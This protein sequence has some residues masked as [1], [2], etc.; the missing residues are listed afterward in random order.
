VWLPKLGPWSGENE[1]HSAV[2]QGTELRTYRLILPRVFHS[3]AYEAGG[4]RQRLEYARIAP[5]GRHVAVFVGDS[6]VL[7]NLGDSAAR[8][9]SFLAAD[10]V[11]LRFGPSG[12]L[13]TGSRTELTRYAF[14]PSP[15]GDGRVGP[16][17]QRF[18]V[19][20]G[21]GW[22][23]TADGRLAAVGCFDAGALLFRDQTATPLRLGPQGDVRMTALSPDGRWVVTASHWR[24]AT[25]GVKVWDTRS[26]QL[27]KALSSESGLPQFSPDGAYLGLAGPSIRLW[28]TDSWEEIPAVSGRRFAFSPDGL[29]AVAEGEAILLLDV[30]TREEL[31][32]L[33]APQESV[34]IPQWFSPDGTLLIATGFESDS[35]MIWDLRALREELAT[36]GLDW[37]HPAYPAERP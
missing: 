15:N 1:P 7:F 21:E 3:R 16:P 30:A 11:P 10:Q 14:H 6:T 19:A 5:D 4:R 28:R 25:S 32:C 27:V 35:L 22:S 17:E 24:F 9:T 29:L 20:S 18:R 12:T 33:E 31:A 26:G 8:P 2:L 36:R 37:D 34:P 23:C 13:W